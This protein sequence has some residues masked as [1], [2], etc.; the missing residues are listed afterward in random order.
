MTKEEMIKELIEEMSECDLFIG[1][2]DARNGNKDFMYGIQTVMEYLSYKVSD[3]YGENFSNTF[4]KNM[5]DSE[6][7]VR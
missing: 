6:S 3:E 2:Y 5:V 1:K 4:L 7:K